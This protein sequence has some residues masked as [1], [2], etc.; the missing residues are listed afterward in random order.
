[1]SISIDGLV[2]VFLEGL[3]EATSRTAANLVKGGPVA[4]VQGGWAAHAK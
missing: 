2:L 4:A 1:L 3:A